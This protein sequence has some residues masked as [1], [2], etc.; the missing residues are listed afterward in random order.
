MTQQFTKIGD[1]FFR[2]DGSGQLTTVTDPDTM[3]GLKA[4]QLGY[5][6]VENTRGLQFTGTS[7]ENQ[8]ANSRLSFSAPS[9]QQGSI[10]Q[11]NVGFT[12][13][14]GAPN[15]AGQGNDLE[16]MLKQRL[17]QALTDFNGVSNVAE[18]EERRQSI[19]RRQLLSAPFSEKGEDTLTGAQKL[20]LMRSRGAEFEPLLKGLEAE[21][22]EKKALPLQQLQ[23]LTAM[24]SLAGDLGL[25][26][27]KK[28]DELRQKYPQ[29]ASADTMEEALG[30]LGVEI[31]A[32]KDL[33]RRVKEAGITSSL[34]SAAASRASAEKNRAA[35]EALREDAENP[36]VE[37][38]KQLPAGQ[39]VMMS[40]AR[41]LPGIL[42][43]LETLINDNEDLFGKIINTEIPFTDTKVFKAFGERTAKAED[44]LRRASQLIGRFMEGGVLR[45]EDEIKYAKMLPELSDLNPSVAMDKLDGVRAM[46]GLKYNNY[47]IDFGASDYD[48]SG[49]NPIDFNA[50]AVEEGR[51]RVRVIQTG[52]T[53]TIEVGE[54]DPSLYEKI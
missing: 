37:P 39:V 20:S 28:L 40:D 36:E 42:D 46:L 54:F 34:A 12:P 30:M 35:A 24:A 29:I 17:T 7:S 23:S 8:A 5:T 52:Q 33:E 14:T 53:G 21:I 41:L 48:V 49:F 43:E 16:A 1:T 2:Q 18:L 15:G 50:T 26:E 19:L 22:I 6:A 45:K 31:A 44:D 25:L 47:I 27:G 32:D 4:G 38:P 51:V 10:P 13:D 3:K 9:T 11:T